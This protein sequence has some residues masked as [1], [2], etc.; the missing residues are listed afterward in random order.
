M[1]SSIFR[2]TNPENREKNPRII[3]EHSMKIIWTSTIDAYD[4]DTSLSQN[5]GMTILMEES[6][7][8]SLG[9]GVAY[10]WTKTLLLQLFVLV[11]TVWNHHQHGKKH[12]KKWDAQSGKREGYVKIQIS[13]G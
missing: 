11:H 7:D 10:V 2:G 13:I 9:L 8:K 4:E 5:G 1:N 12:G 3:H 6:D